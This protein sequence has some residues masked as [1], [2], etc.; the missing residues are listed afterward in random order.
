MKV[1]VSL[2]GDGFNVKDLQVYLKKVLKTKYELQILQELGKPKKVGFN[3]GEPCEY[4]FCWL[5]GISLIQLERIGRVF[6]TY[7]IDE[8]AIN[9][10]ENDIRDEISICINKEL[11]SIASSIGATIEIIKK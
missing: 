2:L 4:G 9:I 6:K 3:K 1:D 10:D 5:N 8:I 7:N 11:I